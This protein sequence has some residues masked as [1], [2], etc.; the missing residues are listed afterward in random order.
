MGMVEFIGLIKVNIVR[1][2]NLVVRD[3]VTSDPYVILTLGHQVRGLA[4]EK[5][6]LCFWFPS[7]VFIWQNFHVFLTV[8]VNENTGDKEQLKSCVEWNANVVDSRSRPTSK[9]GKLI[10]QVK[11]W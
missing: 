1:G 7:D 3:L 10:L 9:A 6:T 11:L 5:P 8:S 2:K 4:D